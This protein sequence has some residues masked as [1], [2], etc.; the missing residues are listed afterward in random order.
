M[1]EEEYV[2]GIDLG[3][4]K[5]S[6]ARYDEHHQ[7][8]EVIKNKEGKERI[9]S[10][11]RF[12]KEG[13]I[14]GEEARRSSQG[15]IIYETKRFIGKKYDSEI[16]KEGKKLTYKIRRN[17][18]NGEV[19]IGVNE[20]EW[21]SA[22]EIGNMIIRKLIEEAKEEY[23]IAPKKAVIA[24]PAHFKDEERKATIY[25]GEIAGL[26]IIGIIN[27]P[28][29]AAIAYGY[30]KKY[31]E[32][33]TILVFDIG[34]GTFDIT[35]IRTNKR[36]QRVIA[37]EG[38]TH[39]G[40]KDIDRKVG[41]IVMKK[42]KEIDKEKAEESYK[43]N[44][45]KIEMI[46][47]EIKIILS[48]NQRCNVDLSEFYEEDNEED[49]P[50]IEITRKEIEEASKDIFEKC[51][52][53]IE[54]M[55]Q[56]I[57]LKNK[58]I[59]KES[60]EEVILVG[61]TSKI[62]KIREMVS[63]YFDLIPN[64]EIDPDQTVARGAA[65][66][67][68]DLFKEGLIKKNKFNKDHFNEDLIHNFIQTKEDLIK[69]KEDLI[70]P[71][72][73]LIKPKEELT[74]DIIKKG[75]KDIEEEE[76]EDIIKRKKEEL[77]IPTYIDITS[78]SIQLKTK[79]GFSTL[80]KRFTRLP[81]K[82]IQEFKTST[83]YS[84]TACFPIFEGEGNK[85]EEL[86]YLETF[87]ITGL[88]ELPAGAVRFEV[89]CEITL[90]G[91]IHIIARTIEPENLLLKEEIKVTNKNQKEKQQNLESLIQRSNLLDIQDIEF[92]KIKS[93]LAEK[94]RLLHQLKKLGKFNEI[95]LLNSWFSSNPNAS[96]LQIKSF[97]DNFILSFP[98]LK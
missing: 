58:G 55:F 10:I 44:K 62:P 18:K 84:T 23:K 37:T 39:L 31:E 71:K 48:T 60:V 1:N 22:E 73:D 69:P 89:E 11:V 27:E 14:I 21:Y 74:E 38:E 42:W 67:G 25:A 82:H 88:P 6:I 72:E 96:S 41:E 20:E 2:V 16:E 13:R 90:D 19:E 78:H 95:F 46:S 85:E 87:T 56:D 86:S 70:K 9:E 61:G 94:N 76:E 29:A 17:E 12:T 32:G 3:T 93:L 91:T 50:N 30:D 49:I 33:K 43:R 68:F 34:G 63:E 64:R 5:S 40:G 92:K 51:I 47:E 4:T 7:R 81:T 77:N 65:L 35:L 83:E 98:F 54:R 66:V 52:K 97:L 8:V 57:E 59:T 80:I 26:E 24:V 36:N 79:Q 75:K 45:Y 53:C 15:V 28:T